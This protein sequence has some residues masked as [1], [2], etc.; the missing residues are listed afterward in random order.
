MDL[1]L[2]VAETAPGTDAEK[3]T[4]AESF[5]E[6]IERK[7]RVAGRCGGSLVEISQCAMMGSLGSF[8]GVDF[9]GDDT[10]HRSGPL[11]LE[12]AAAVSYLRSTWAN[13]AQTARKRGWPPLK[14]RRGRS[15]IQ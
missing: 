2:T 7:P 12:S 6:S 5:P 8:G 1:N 15:N 4:S 3:K 13:P 11:V 14:C 10:T 9:H